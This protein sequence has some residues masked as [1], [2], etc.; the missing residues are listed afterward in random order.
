MNPSAARDE[1]SDRTVN[2][3]IKLAY[4]NG[5]DGW[6]MLNIYP[7]RATNAAIHLSTNVNNRLNFNNL[8]IIKK[9]I[10]ENKIKEIWGAWGDIDAKRPWLTTVKTQ[11]V[12]MVQSLGCRIFYFGALTKKYHN[13]PH[14]LYLVVDFTKKKYL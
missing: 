6:I 1:Y 3:V 7:Q 13:P 4:Q 12:Q 11:I 8:E 10:T 9:Y 14:P 5:Y 2:K